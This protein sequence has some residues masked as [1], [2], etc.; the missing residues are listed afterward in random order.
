MEV[1]LALPDDWAA[2]LPKPPILMFTVE[3]CAV[4]ATTPSPTNTHCRSSVWEGDGVQGLDGGAS[5]GWMKRTRAD[6]LG[7]LSM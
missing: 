3:G 6:K 2:P 1:L 7:D 5:L 4:G